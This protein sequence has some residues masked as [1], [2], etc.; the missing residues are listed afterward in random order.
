MNLA[1]PIT[2]DD[3]PHFER[4]LLSTT[5]LGASTSLAVSLLG[6]VTSRGPFVSPV[7]VLTLAASVTL[8]LGSQLNPGHRLLLLLAA[9]LTSLV[10]PLSWAVWAFVGALG[11]GL[12]AGRATWT[13]KLG[14]LGA[15]L[16]GGLWFLAVEHSLA[17]RHGLV[18]GAL[19][20]LAALAPGLFIGLALAPAHLVRRSTGLGLRLRRL[21]D[22]APL[23]EAAQFMRAGEHWERLLA[24]LHRLP[25]GA[26]RRELVEHAHQSVRDLVAQADEVTRLRATVAT[27]DLPAGRHHLDALRKRAENAPDSR[28][29]EHLAHAARLQADSLE[30]AEGLERKRDRAE[31]RLS[32]A[33]SR[34][35]KATVAVELTPIN[36]NGLQETVSR[37]RQP[38]VD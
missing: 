17:H 34:L 1:L 4:T 3:R 31:A 7:V 15:T 32:L 26:E 6:L 11:L 37:L 18:G 24:A 10:V 2:F 8:V 30:Q 28:A 9:G 36:Q 29:R 22:A 19:H 20:L 21:S 38:L 13:A 16:A 5:V 23:Q 35:E 33:F 12:A 25:V 27:L 14:A